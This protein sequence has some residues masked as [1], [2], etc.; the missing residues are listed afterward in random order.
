[1]RTGVVRF[2]SRRSRSTLD[3]YAP[4]ARRALFTSRQNAFVDGS[5]EIEA[6]HL[7]SA[8]LTAD[9]PRLATLLAHAHIARAE[10]KLLV[11][12]P[13]IHRIA[14][15][16][17]PR[18]IPFSEELSAVLAVASD[19]AD[20]QAQ[21]TIGT[22]HLLLALLQEEEVASDRIEAFRRALREPA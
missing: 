17:K 20:A 19:E 22:E 14:G 12:A 5:T 4:A 16:D 9:D 13:P 3:R 8:I 15:A 10:L 11:T 6:H 1:V 18:E 21:A 7:L 2:A